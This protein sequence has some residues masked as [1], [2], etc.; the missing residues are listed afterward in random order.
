MRYIIDEYYDDVMSTID[1]YEDKFTFITHVYPSKPHSFMRV[2]VPTRTHDYMCF[3]KIFFK[4]PHNSPYGC[5]F[6]EE[7]EQGDDYWF[8]SRRDNAEEVAEF[9]AEIC[10]TMY[11]R[12]NEDQFIEIVDK[13]DEIFTG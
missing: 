7:L 9:L 6:I 3:G 5:F 11:Y 1:D 10:G 12:A 2:K 8:P 4:I 13:F